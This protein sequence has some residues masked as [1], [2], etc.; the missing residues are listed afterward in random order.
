[1]VCRYLLLAVLTVVP[2]LS[3]GVGGGVYYDP[4]TSTALS[5]ALGANAAEEQKI[6]DDIHEILKNYRKS[7][8]EALVI[9][10]SRRLEYEALRDAGDFGIAAESRYYR[11]IHDLV[12]DCIMPAVWRVALRSIKH[13]DDVL[14]W[15]PF[16]YRTVTDVRQLCVQYATVVAN[17][18]RSTDF[19]DIFFLTIENKDLLALF[20]L[21]QFYKLDFRGLLDNLASFDM[22]SA[23]EAVSHDLEEL[24]SVGAG[25]ATA[26]SSIA[27]D[28]WNETSAIGKR[29]V[30]KVRTVKG[31][32]TAYE[33]VREVLSDTR[34]LRRYLL[35][36]VGSLDSLGVAKMFNL[37]DGLDISKYISDYTATVAGMY[38]RQRW[39]IYQGIMDSRTVV[40][41]TEYDSRTMNLDAFLAD[42]NGRCA[43]MN[44]AEEEGVL[45]P[46]FNYKVGHDEKRFYSDSSE[47]SFAGSSKAV[48]TT[49]CAED[50]EI[51]SGNFRF[52]CPEEQDG[53]RKGIESYLKLHGNSEDICVQ[54]ARYLLASEE[55]MFGG[56]GGRGRIFSDIMD[57]QAS[58][59]NIEWE[60]YGFFETTDGGKLR[61]TELPK[62]DGEGV[63]YHRYGH[64]RDTGLPVSLDAEICMV[65]PAH[66]FWHLTGTVVHTDDV[67]E[68][69]FDEG[70]SESDILSKIEK[71]T[72]RLELSYPDCTIDVDYSRREAI[73]ADTLD[74]TRHLLW[75]S[76]RCRL[77]QE[78]EDKLLTIYAKL[79]TVEHYMYCA[80]DV[81]AEPRDLLLLVAGHVQRGGI[82]N[83]AHRRWLSAADSALHI[84]P[85]KKAVSGK[86][87]D[88]S[89]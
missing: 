26:G 76:E 88:R 67:E 85:E 74:N 65:N 54:V 82:A 8:A 83:A 75:M 28:S 87:K 18:A 81:L 77:A 46:L 73:T 79:I 4:E 38:Y 55:G 43:S 22:E 56:V 21:A 61:Y 52:F 64:I 41:K 31:L 10:D 66:R 24:I 71:A 5:L 20:D 29:I 19:S 15:G 58:V 27:I 37:R 49:Y 33:T 48:F 59:Y 25:I 2:S 45:M 40:Y 50:V 36:C 62:C 35:S 44:Y 13:P 86:G 17:G 69:S 60:G 9:W 70:A 47:T 68:L 7:T 30:E 89:V 3:F 14:N 72:K 34:Y 11:R 6:L 42:L 12:A 57:E 16:L 1:M 84:R 80:D 32:K 78:I 39:Y 23:K 51:G 63:W 53:D